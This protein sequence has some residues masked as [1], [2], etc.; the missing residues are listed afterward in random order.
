MN[1]DLQGQ[2]FGALMSKLRNPPEL[3]IPLLIGN[4]VASLKSPADFSDL[5]LK[6]DCEKSSIKKGWQ[7]ACYW[8]K[9]L[10]WLPSIGEFV[11]YASFIAIL[12]ILIEII[13]NNYIANRVKKESR[14][15][16]DKQEQKNQVTAVDEGGNGLYTVKYA[17]GKKE[18]P[19]ITC[20]QS[21]MGATTNTYNVKYWDYAAN[22][23]KG[24]NAQ[25][26]VVCRQPFT[27]VG[28]LSGP[29]P[30]SSLY[31]VGDSQLVDYMR[32]NDKTYFGI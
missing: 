16:R 1:A 12:F 14:C 31:F 21:G 30:G 23:S 32:T 27:A 19:V 15:M 29:A 17:P 6:L 7:V 10:E 24:A 4:Q 13:H 8:V 9:S 26:D 3:K 20:E 28:G 18:A 25:K 11:I 2:Q 5:L 22:D